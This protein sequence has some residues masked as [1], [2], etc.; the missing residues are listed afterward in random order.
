MWLTRLAREIWKRRTEACQIGTLPSDIDEAPTHLEDERWWDGSRWR[1]VCGE[2]GVLDEVDAVY[3]GLEKELGEHVSPDKDSES[4]K[5]CM[6]KGE[7]KRWFHM[8]T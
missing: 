4:C 8:L 1:E 7:I 2:R 6:S 5:C 3:L